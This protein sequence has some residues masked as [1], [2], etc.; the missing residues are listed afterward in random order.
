MSRADLAAQDLASEVGLTELPSDLEKAATTLGIMIA[1]QPGDLELSGILLRRDGQLAIGLN[2]QCMS[3]SQRFALA[4]LI[5]HAH[6]HRSR[7][8]IL[9]IA[10]RTAH[11]PLACLPTDREEAETNRFPG[12]LLIPETAVRPP[13]PSSRRPPSSPPPLPASSTSA[14]W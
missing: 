13:R 5:G 8:L 7:N 6:L 14:K 1:R 9:G 10:D 4:H 3:A 12:A 2:P 11:G